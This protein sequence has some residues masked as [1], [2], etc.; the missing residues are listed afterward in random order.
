MSASTT[1]PTGPLRV[2]D[3]GFRAGGKR[4]LLDEHVEERE[5][6]LHFYR[7]SV[8]D[9]WYMRLE[10]SLRDPTLQEGLEH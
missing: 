4:I 8:N 3:V 1:P 5:F 10:D 9:P 2:E 7:D 6:I